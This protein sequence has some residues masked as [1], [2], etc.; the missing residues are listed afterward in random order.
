MFFCCVFSI[1]LEI[2]QDLP[3]V[4]VVFASVGGGGMI[5]GIASYLKQKNPK[6]KASIF[7]L[8]YEFAWKQSLPGA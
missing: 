6:I 8:S 4:D 3:D 5:S 7:L 2:I 1:R